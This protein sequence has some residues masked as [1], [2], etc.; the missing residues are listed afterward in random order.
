MAQPRRHFVVDENGRKKSVVLPIKQYQELLEDLH[1]L[2]LMAERKA[3][4]SEPLDVVRKRL[5]SKWRNTRSR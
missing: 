5:E 1:D 2:A 4:P 3:E